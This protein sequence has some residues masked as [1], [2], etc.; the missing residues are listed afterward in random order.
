MGN[1]TREYLSYSAIVETLNALN[2]KQA[3]GLIIILMMVTTALTCF[4]IG[5]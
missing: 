2:V 5:T 4:S 3:I 1:Y